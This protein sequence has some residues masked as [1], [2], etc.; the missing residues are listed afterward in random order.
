MA[1]RAITQSLIDQAMDAQRSWFDTEAYSWT[2][3]TLSLL[4]TVWMNLLPELRKWDL[5]SWI[6]KLFQPNNVSWSVWDVAEY[7]SSSPQAAQN[8]ANVL[9]KN[10][11]D[12]WIDDLRMFARN[13]K[14]ISDAAKAAYDQLPI[15]WKNA[16]NK[17]TKD[18]M[19]NYINQIYWSNS[20]IAK[21]ARIIL[22]N[23]STNPADLIKYLGKIPGEVSFGPY[24]SSIRLKNWTQASAVLKNT[25]YDRQLDSLAWG[26]DSRLRDGFTQADIEDISKLKWFSDVATKQWDLFYEYWGKNISLKNDLIGSDLKQKVCH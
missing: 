6:R 22:S 26:F 23:G 9:W 15:E 4:W 14:E 20:E 13:F 24:V 10:V 18:L 3:E 8:I 7:M 16:A 11:G 1:D 17:W 21:T 25:N 2:S 12:I 19:N 5:I